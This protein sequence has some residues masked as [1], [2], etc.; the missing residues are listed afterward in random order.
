MIFGRN[1]CEIKQQV[2]VSEPHFGE[3]RHEARPWLM[4]RW[5]ANGRVSIRLDLTFL[6]SVTVP[7]L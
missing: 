3:V 2:W 6:E 1:C 5:K 4:A 7:Q